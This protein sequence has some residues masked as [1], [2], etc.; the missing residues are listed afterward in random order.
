M[1]KVFFVTRRNFHCIFVLLETVDVLWFF[2]EKS[3]EN[4]VE[5]VLRD[6]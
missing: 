4:L 6:A 5:I 1:N 3:R 2:V